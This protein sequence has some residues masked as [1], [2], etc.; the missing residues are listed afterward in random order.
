VILL[1]GNGM[2]CWGFKTAFSL[3][4]RNS[5]LRPLS[6]LLSGHLSAMANCTQVRTIEAN[7]L[8]IPFRSRQPIVLGILK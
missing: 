1:P 3:T 7:E 5:L 6:A 4:H 8:F 2:T